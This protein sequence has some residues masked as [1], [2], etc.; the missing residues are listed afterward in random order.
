V[1]AGT[2]LASSGGITANVDGQ[3]INAKNI[4]GGV[5]VSANNV[6]IQNSKITVGG[7][8]SS[9]GVTIDSG[10]TGTRIINT[11]ITA[12]NGFQGIQG[13]GGFVAQGVNIHGFEHGVEIRGAATVLDSWI[14]VTGGWKYPDGTTPHFDAVCG[15]SVNGVVV[16][17]NTLIANP[18]QTGAVNF[19]NDFGSITNVQIDNNLLVGGGYALY[20]R[21]DSSWFSPT[22]GKPVTG[23]SVTN[24]RFGHSQWGYSSVV[25]AQVSFSGNVDDTTGAHILG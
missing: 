15:W 16:R 6:T 19:T 7:G 12:P 9:V 23:I 17:H 8:D 4:N 24:N 13:A 2:V 5:R 10:R 14:S 20:L 11:E 18:D 22:A 1:P 3:V 21:G 25:N